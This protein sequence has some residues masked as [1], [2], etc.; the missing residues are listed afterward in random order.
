MR[1]RGKGVY[2][3][4]FHAILV[5]PNM[6]DRALLQKLAVAKLFK[7]PAGYN[8]TLIPANLIVTAGQ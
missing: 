1:H 4:S 7:K 8:E 3:K 6:W 5:T 2:L